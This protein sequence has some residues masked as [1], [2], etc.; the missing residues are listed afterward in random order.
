MARKDRGVC[1][2]GCNEIAHMSE[3][4]ARPANVWEE[5]EERKPFMTASSGP[6]SRWMRRASCIRPGTLDLGLAA[7]SLA[8]IDG[9]QGVVSGRTRPLA[10]NCSAKRR[11][12]A[13]RP[14]AKIKRED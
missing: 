14:V 13:N 4:T 8:T 11:R 5:D 1:A 3:R 12:K 2:R 7:I 10:K 9:R 6:R